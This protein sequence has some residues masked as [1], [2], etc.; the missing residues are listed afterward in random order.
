MRVVIVGSGAIGTWIGA[1]LARAGEDVVLVA[2][3]PHREAMAAHGV[4]VRAADEEDYRVAPAVVGSAEEAEHADAVI[5]SVK[6]HD[7]PAVARGVGT[8][9]A[10]DTPV[11][12]AQNG[13]PWWWFHPEGRT[14]EAV[15]PGG[16]VFSAI[17]P[18]HALGLVVYLGAAILEPGV[19]STRPEAGLIIGEPDGTSSARLGAVADALE[20]GGFPVRRT[21]EIRKEIWTKLMGNA[22]FNPVSVLTRAGLGTMVHDPG[23]QDVVR[24]I[25]HEVVA[26]AAAAGAA[27]EMSI[28]DR[29]ALTGLLGDHKT[30]TLQDV[31]AGK[32]LELAALCGA[33]VE[34]A[35]GAGVPV[36][37]LRTVTALAELHAR[38]S[39]SAS[40]FV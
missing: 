27:P 13:I 11:V 3:G 39:I 35:D 6:S 25:M 26:V 9:L 7:T 24:S 32:P 2:R 8:L 29:I 12:T 37:T 19:V 5:L 28:E 16:V 33:V 34:L 15:D 1:A 4:L 40:A 21:P 10:D 17:P 20:R 14:V 18:S 38:V 23:V 22:S 36:P 31:E 30:S